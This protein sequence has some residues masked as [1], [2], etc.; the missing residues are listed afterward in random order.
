VVSGTFDL[1]VTLP[2]GEIIFLITAFAFGSL[3]GGE[4]VGFFPIVQDAELLRHFHL[5]IVPFHGMDEFYGNFD[6]FG[7]ILSDDIIRRDEGAE[8]GRTGSC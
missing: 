1:V 3:Q 6:C 8:M 2:E 7:V 4:Q 5:H